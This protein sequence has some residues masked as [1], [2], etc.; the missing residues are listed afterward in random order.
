MKKMASSYD[1]VQVSILSDDER[2]VHLCDEPVKLDLSRQSET[3]N[4]CFTKGKSYQSY[5]FSTK[6]CETN[7][8]ALSIF[9]SKMGKIVKNERYVF[10][11]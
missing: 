1:N 2:F 9:Y 3:A 5:I 4:L 11:L 10:L 8:H 7:D 6:K